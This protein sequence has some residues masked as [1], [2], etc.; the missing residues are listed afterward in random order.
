MADRFELR[1]QMERLQPIGRM[2][3]E[4]Y[5]HIRVD[6][7]TIKLVKPANFVDEEIK[8]VTKK[9]KLWS[10]EKLKSCPKEKEV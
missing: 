4:K 3:F 5:E 7:K 1:K 2:Y 6:E 10:E 8:K 9:G